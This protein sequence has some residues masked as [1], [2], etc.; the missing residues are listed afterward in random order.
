[1]PT[2]AAG[3]GGL[4]FVA[5]MKPADFGPSHDPTGAGRFD[6]ACLGRVLADRKVR[7][8]A[9]V[10]REV[11]AKHAS[12]MSFVEDDDVVQTLAADRPDDALD[13]GILPGRARGGADGREAE[14]FDG[15]AER[16]IEGRVA[17]VQEKSGGGVVRERLPE[18][19]A[20]PR[21]GGMPR[22]VEMQDAAAV[23]GEDDEDE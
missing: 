20:G 9:Q 21:R 4:P 14:R 12:E 7:A 18:L 23:V 5:M 13:I 3:S 6:S 8:R 19:L 16:R 1:M 2:E 11:G 10:I 22:H 17:V 15:A